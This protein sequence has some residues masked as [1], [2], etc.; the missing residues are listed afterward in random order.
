MKAMVL[1]EIMPVEDEPLR[2]MDVPDPVPGLKQILVKVSVC[3]LC[4]TELDEIE[5]G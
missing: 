5:E 4:H 1:N 3:G 2:M